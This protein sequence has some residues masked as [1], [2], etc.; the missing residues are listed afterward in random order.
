MDELKYCM[1]C[2][3]HTAP[4]TSGFFEDGCCPMCGDQLYDV[5]DL[6]DAYES[7]R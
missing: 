3:E 4:D 1:N 6:A 5:S 2:E 7:D